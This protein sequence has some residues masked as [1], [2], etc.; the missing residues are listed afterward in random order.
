MLAAGERIVRRRFLQLLAGACTAPAAAACASA[1]AVPASQPPGE[2]PPGSAPTAAARVAPKQLGRWLHVPSSPQL[3]YAHLY[4]AQEQ[5]W[6]QEEG[7]GLE[8]EYITADPNQVRALI[9]GTAD[10]IESSPSA[11]LAVIASGSPLKTLGAFL[12]KP[13]TILASQASIRNLQ[14][15]AGKSIGISTAGGFPQVATTLL[16]EENG[17]DVSTVDWVPVGSVADIFRALVAGKVDVAFTSSNFLPEI[18]DNKDLRL[19][20]AFAD[21][22]PSFVRGNL[23]VTEKTMSERPDAVVAFL[24]ATLKGVRVFLEDKRETVD[25]VN[26]VT[27]QDKRLLE[28]Q[29]EWM[30]QRRIPDPN[31]WLDR[32]GLDFMQRQNVKAGAQKEVLPFEKVADPSFRAKALAKIGEYTPRTTQ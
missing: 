15:V 32:T 9:G 25:A 12:P 14:E 26:R 31:L 1:P 6:Y 16:L 19:L 4:I 28:V 21:D 11:G 20:S 2:P 3:Q 8:L 10:S 18:Q 22:L 27:N 7:L 23:F 5:G 13:D 24:A 17:V 29:W 30:V